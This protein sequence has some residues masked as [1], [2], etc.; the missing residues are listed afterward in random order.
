MSTDALARSRRVLGPDH[1]NSIMSLNNHAAIVHKL[2]R[3]AEAAALYKEAMERAAACP[4]L[5]P[6]HPNTKTYAGNYANLL[7]ELGRTAEAGAIRAR[8]GVKE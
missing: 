5:G 3:A 2:G 4:S 6:G 7:E 1:P 8:F